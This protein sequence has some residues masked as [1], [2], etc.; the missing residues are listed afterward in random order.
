[1]ASKREGWGLVITEGAVRGRPSVAYNTW[2][3]K[4]AID[5]G[6]TGHLAPTMDPTG[7]AQAWRETI[8]SY[9][10]YERVRTAAWK[11]A[12]KLS[13]TDAADIFLTHAAAIAGL[14]PTI[15]EDRSLPSVSVV[16]PTLNAGRLLGECLAAIRDQD[17][18]QVKVEILIADG[19]STDD[20]RTIAKRFKANVFENPLKTGEAGKAVGV[21]KANND[22]IALIDSDNILVDRQWLRKM[23]AP[24]TEPSIIGSEPLHYQ[25]RPSDGL[26]TRYT[27]LLG[28]GDPLVLFLGNYD[29]YSTLT[30]RWTDLPIPFQERKGWIDVTLQ[31]PLIPTIGAN[32][33]IFRRSFLQ[34]A[35]L[36][37]AN[38]DYL[39]DIDLLAEVA[40]KTPVHFAKVKTGIVHVFAGTVAIFAKKQ[41]RR[42]RDF[43]YYQ[44]SGVRSY[45]W[46]KT[47]Q[48]GRI[49]FILSCLT[50]VPLLA[51]ALIGFSRKPDVVWFFHP[52]AAYVTLITYA[53]GYLSFQFDPTIASRAG[54]RQT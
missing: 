18:P 42:V 54:W 23:V 24:F 22:L 1:M 40:A 28:M 33:T 26:I 10:H 15:A 48:W 52:I 35:L 5:D 39:F 36:S 30:N 45:P 47:N 19:G 7:L 17:Y 8:K 53:Y 14:D 37:T 49:A 3:T 32:G 43:L 4:D 25:Y 16:I 38:D 11:T 20:T 44:R 34:P 6:V 27:A 2:G 9:S 41:F 21:K 29:R 46:G 31:P 50:L 51:Q 12:T 13:S